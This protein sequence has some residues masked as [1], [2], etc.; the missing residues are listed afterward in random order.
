LSGNDYGLNLQVGGN[1]ADRFRMVTDTQ[2]E[3]MG[4]AFLDP[5]VQEGP[6]VGLKKA[7]CIRVPCRRYGAGHRFALGDDEF[8]LSVLG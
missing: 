3:V 7:S 2:R 4:R 6:Y 5:P 1:F 8:E